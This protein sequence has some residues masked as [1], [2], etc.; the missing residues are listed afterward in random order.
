MAD[1]LQSYSLIVE[2]HLILDVT[3]AG[4]KIFVT[5]MQLI[6]ETGY[7]AAFQ[8]EL[9]EPGIPYTVDGPWPKRLTRHAL[10][11]TRGQAL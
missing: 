9:T 3:S 4:E 10:R 2:E 1:Y 8:E 11:L 7:A 5:W 6:V